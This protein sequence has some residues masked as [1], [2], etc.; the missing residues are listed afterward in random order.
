MGR[1][2]GNQESSE[3]PSKATEKQQPGREKG[4]LGVVSRQG[5]R[6]CGAAV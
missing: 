4:K 3:E 6:V 5:G 1:D 2:P